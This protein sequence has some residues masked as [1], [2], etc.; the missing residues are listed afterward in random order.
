LTEERFSGKVPLPDGFLETNS[1]IKLEHFHY[2]NR[3]N[4]STIE[5]VVK[6][7]GIFISTVTQIIYDRRDSLLDTHENA[8]QIISEIEIRFT[9]L[10]CILI[11]QISYPSERNLT[12]FICPI[13]SYHNVLNSNN[14][15]EKSN[16]TYHEPLALTA[17]ERFWSTI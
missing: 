9:T 3:I 5:K 4:R 8:W 14:C 13:S 10:S 6:T 15:I 7:A 11:T 2:M 1:I 12:N 17:A 16:Y